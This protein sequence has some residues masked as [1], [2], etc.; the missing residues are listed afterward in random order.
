MGLKSWNPPEAL[1]QRFRLASFELT[2]PGISWES[3]NTVKADQ[4]CIVQM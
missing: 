4:E 3:A 2:A 1:M